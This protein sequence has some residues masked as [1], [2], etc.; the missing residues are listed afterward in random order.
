MVYK[1]SP[2]R[3][4]PARGHIT[5]E[6][7]A[8]GQFRSSIDQFKAN[9]RTWLAKVKAKG[10]QDIHDKVV[11]D[12]FD[13]EAFKAYG[14][15]QERIQDLAELMGWLGRAVA[16]AQRD[17]SVI[18]IFTPGSVREHKLFPMPPEQLPP[19]APLDQPAPTF[20]M[21]MRTLKDGNGKVF[22][23]VFPDPK[24]IGRNNPEFKHL[25]EQAEQKAKT[26]GS[27]VKFFESLGKKY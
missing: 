4:P 18:H 10:K 3:G 7:R 14:D 9:V 22:Q 11:A 24:V 6:A 20:G 13:L 25:W 2:P 8:M 15:I 21:V 23:T 17:A 5:P 12:Q 26:V 27:K 16:H 19:L 1:K